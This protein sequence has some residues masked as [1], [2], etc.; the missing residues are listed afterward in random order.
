[1][2]NGVGSHLHNFGLVSIDL[3]IRIISI[4]SFVFETNWHPCVVPLTQ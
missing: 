3:I 4:H 2:N 1:M